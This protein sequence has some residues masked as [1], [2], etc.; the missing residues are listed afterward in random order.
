M[1]ALGFCCLFFL[2]F[3]LEGG[4]LSLVV[5]EAGPLFTEVWGFPL[6]GLSV[7]PSAGFKLG[8]PVVTYADSAVASRGPWSSAVALHSLSCSQADGIFPDGEWNTRPLHWHA[9]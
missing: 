8:A 6:R 4:I 2:F 5:G 1:A 3:F 9:S 7:L